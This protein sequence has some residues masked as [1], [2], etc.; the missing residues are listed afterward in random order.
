MTILKII[1]NYFL[2]ATASSQ[3]VFIFSFRRYFYS[4]NHNSLHYFQR[5]GFS[6]ERSTNMKEPISLVLDICDP[7]SHLWSVFFLIYVSYFDYRSLEII[8]TLRLEV[9]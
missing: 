6:L 1:D 9:I 3:N 8:N 5:F 7:R 2:P 4:S